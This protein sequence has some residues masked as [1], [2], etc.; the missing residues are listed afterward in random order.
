M[1][2]QSCL[3]NIQSIGGSYVSVRINYH[4]SISLPL[5]PELPILRSSFCPSIL[6]QKCSRTRST[7]ASLHTFLSCMAQIRSARRG[8]KRGCPSRCGTVPETHACNSA[9]ISDGSCRCRLALASARDRTS[10]RLLH[11]RFL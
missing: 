7:S 6:L 10:R 9:C 1:R 11:R 3:E 4:V 2:G 8:R 5:R